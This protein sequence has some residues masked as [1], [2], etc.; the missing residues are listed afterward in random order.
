MKCKNQCEY[1]RGK[2]IYCGDPQEIIGNR[3]K[4]IKVKNKRITSEFQYT[5]D[6][7]MTYLKED[8][9]KKGNFGKYAGII[10]RVGT[11][12]AR[13]WIRDMKE[14]RITNPAYFMTIYKNSNQ[15]KISILELFC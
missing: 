12:Q 8:L 6:E 9:Y 15:T 10:K 4:E 14:R 7:V 5:V 2:C 11:D 3:R 1:S 13:I